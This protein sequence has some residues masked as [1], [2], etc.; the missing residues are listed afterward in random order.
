[1]RVFIDTNVV[2]DFVSQRPPWAAAAT[3][4]FD[5]IARGEHEG[6]VAPHTFTTAHYLLRNQIGAQR[7]AAALVD[8]VTAV[9][10]ATVT[11]ESVVQAL[12]LA[13]KDFEDALQVVAALSVNADVVVTRDPRDL[14]A[15]P[16]RVMDPQELLAFLQG[17]S[18]E[19]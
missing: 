10:V 15:C 7:T 8:L 19:S 13:W 16:I 14:L 5:M 9:K 17:Q 1:M 4:L 12:A 2:I 6:F 11:H 3:V 18:A